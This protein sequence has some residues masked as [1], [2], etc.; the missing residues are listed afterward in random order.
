ML[1]VR[2]LHAR[3]AHDDVICNPIGARSCP[4][5]RNREEEGAFANI[6]RLTT[7]VARCGDLSPIWLLL[8]RFGDKNVKSI[9]GDKNWLHLEN[10]WRFSD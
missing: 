6:G 10:Q 3:G 4:R 2:I 7:S 9:V 1:A 5:L 8:F